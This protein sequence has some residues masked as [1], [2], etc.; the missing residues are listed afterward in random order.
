MRSR[1]SAIEE[2]RLS[3]ADSVRT[4]AVAQIPAS[5]IT[6]E[7]LVGEGNFAA[8]YKGLWNG[9]PVALK[10]LKDPRVVESFLAEIEILK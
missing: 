6:I 1:R 7:H 9:A 5:A 2:V 4:K 8:V 3:S 10:K